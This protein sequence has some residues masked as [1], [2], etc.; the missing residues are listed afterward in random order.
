MNEVLPIHFTEI[1]IE[2]EPYKLEFREYKI[3]SRNYKENL[4]EV[5][6]RNKAKDVLYLDNGEPDIPKIKI[7]MPEFLVSA[8]FEDIKNTVDSIEQY[9]VEK[10]FDEEKACFHAIGLNEVYSNFF[11]HGNQ[12]D[13]DK[14]IY[15]YTFYCETDNKL[16]FWSLFE[17]TGAKQFDISHIKPLMKYTNESMRGR[18]TRMIIKASDNYCVF[19]NPLSNSAVL[20]IH[21]NKS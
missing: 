14:P 15:S 21:Q 7:Y 16:N 3:P 12:G 1:N 9:L 20:S 13:V 8:Y 5:M 17:D 18:G 2:G 19:T 4:Y 10:G 11:E 6:I